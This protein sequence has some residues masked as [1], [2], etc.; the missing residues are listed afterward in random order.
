MT[1]AEYLTKWYDTHCTP[2]LSSNTLRGY[3]I[4]IENHIRNPAEGVSRPTVRKYQNNIYDANMLKILLEA[5][6]GTDLY[7]PVTLGASLGLRRGEVL[8]L[9]WKNINLNTR[10]VEIRQ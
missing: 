8:G 1:L 5:A 7:I 6:N 9:Q 3:R 10:R 4:N 2:R